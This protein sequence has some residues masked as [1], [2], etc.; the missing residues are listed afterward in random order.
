MPS[1]PFLASLTLAGVSVAAVPAARKP[2]VAGHSAVAVNPSPFLS[3]PL[4]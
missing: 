4:E 1:F 3:T 2:T